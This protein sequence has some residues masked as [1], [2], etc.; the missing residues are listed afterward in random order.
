MAEKTKEKKPVVRRTQ[1]EIVADLEAKAKAAREKLEAKA[2]KGY[3]QLHA[4]YVKHLDA[5]VAAANVARQELIELDEMAEALGI[6][7]ATIGLG[8]SEGSSVT[9]VLEEGTLV[10]YDFGTD[11]SQLE[12]A[13]EAAEA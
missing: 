3:D 6:D 7:K 4:R 8:Y 13:T 11:Q 12:D 9:N 2:R 5:A 10:T 1:A